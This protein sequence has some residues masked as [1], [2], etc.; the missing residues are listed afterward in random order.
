MLVDKGIE[1]L[2][3]RH[4]SFRHVVM[5]DSSKTSQVFYLFIGMVDLTYVSHELCELFD[6]SR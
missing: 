4:G 6:G 5:Q 2:G 3:L 1:G